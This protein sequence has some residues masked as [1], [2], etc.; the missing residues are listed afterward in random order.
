VD[1]VDGKNAIARWSTGIMSTI[2]SLQRKP[3]FRDQ[4]MWNR[5][6]N[7]RTVL[8]TLMGVGT[9]ILIVTPFTSLSTD[10]MRI[11]VAI[12]FG[13]L[14]WLGMLVLNAK[15][16]T[17]L[18]SHLFVVGGIIL[19]T[20]LVVTDGGVRSGATGWYAIVIVAAG[21]LLGWRA[22]LTTAFVSALLTLTL[23]LLDTSGHLPI[24]EATPLPIDLWFGILCTLVG[25]SSL[26]Y[27]AAR[28][29]SLALR[30]TQHQLH[31]RKRAE[32]ELQ[33]REALLQNILNSIPQAVFW[34]DRDGVYLGCN[35][36]FA[37]A[38][39]LTSPDLVVGKTDFELPW[40]QD[41]AESYRRDDLQVLHQNLP[42]LHIVEPLLQANG[43]RMWIDTSKFPL[44]DENGE[45]NG[46][47]GVFDDITERK[48][49][50]EALCK[51]ESL[52]RALIEHTPDIIANYDQTGRYLFVNS[53]I[54]KVS[55][56]PAREFVGKRMDELELFTREQ[57]LRRLEAITYVY[58]SHLPFEDEFEWHGPDGTLVFEWRAFPAIDS[59]GNV[60][61]VF[62]INR[63]I[64][65]RKRAEEALKESMRQLHNLSLNLEATREQERKAMAREVHDELGQIL[66]AIK[67]AVEGAGRHKPVNQGSTQEQART[68]LELI[69]Y[70]MQ[71]VHRISARLRPMVLDDLGLV[72]AIKW[73]A[74]EFERHTG[75]ACALSLPDAELAIS[76]DQ[77][78]A[79]FRI[80]G[81][82][83][84]NVARHAKATYVQVSLRET[85]SEF[86]LAVK[87]DGIGI[88]ESIKERS[89]CLGLKG[90]DERLYPYGGRRVFAVDS[91]TGTE[92]IIQLPKILGEDSAYHDSHNYCR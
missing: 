90:I 71:E 13:C 11:L 46:I 65:A 12:G 57:T 61:S 16:K 32:H 28:S 60:L 19:V 27:V 92:V 22:G 84:T 48:L 83:L 38:A 36:V 15:G 76:E 86:V 52:Y 1:F 59:E 25:I 73:Q 55:P 87:D 79:L 45:A 82:L 64:T 4:V 66:T 56:I 17:R 41:E 67:M 42:R 20:G 6:E 89:D 8:W 21:L 91:G 29:V 10:Y 30:Q 80:L 2:I 40:P 69:D 63:D 62:S 44:R 81:E 51:S 23:A 37:K 31:D 26:Q 5:A 78:T 75:I 3:P 34:K 58:Q 85:T 7:L 50:D 35:A 33:K 54:R 68:L 14:Q 74:H 49:A 72:A 70:G 88:S 43:N 77:S 53:A 47:L 9:I 24:V 39:G 18:A